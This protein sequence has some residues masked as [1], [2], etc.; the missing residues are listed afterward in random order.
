ML[1]GAQQTQRADHDHEDGG[2]APAIQ[3]NPLGRLWPELGQIEC[4]HD[5]SH[6]T[7]WSFMASW[8]AEICGAWIAAARRVLPWR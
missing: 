3:G 2:N 1:P 6:A 7:L 4:S 5:I 8:D